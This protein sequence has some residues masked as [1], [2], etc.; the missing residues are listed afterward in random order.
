[1]AKSLMKALH[2]EMTAD[3][4]SIA[5]LLQKKGRGK[6]TV[7][8]HITPK[9]AAL[10]KKRG[11]RG[12]TNP[13]TG[14]LEFDDSFNAPDTG[15]SAE[16][17]PVGA[18][19]SQAP[20]MTASSFGGAPALP[21]GGPI[22]DNL[23]AQ[24]FTPQTT[25]DL[26]LQPPVSA[27]VIAPVFGEGSAMPGYSTGYPGITQPPTRF[28]ETQPDFGTAP[29]ATP[30]AGAAPEKSLLQSLGLNKANTL[31]AGLYGLLGAYQARNAA[32]QGQQAKQELLAQ[33]TPYQ[34]QGKQ[35]VTAAQSGQLSP[36]SAQAYQA[37]QAKAAQA[38]Q[39]SGGG[40]GVVQSQAALENLRQQL[41][42]GDL[43]IG[44]QIQAIGDKIAQGAISAGVQA[45]QYV[46][47]L[48]SNYAMNIGRVLMG[49]SPETTTKPGATE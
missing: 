9:E 2:T 7:L 33:A 45:D 26:Q 46:N 40:I 35:L 25:P 18:T 10:L 42:A 37:A 27:P 11:G 36:A 31:G 29:Q 1:M 3:L 8:A 34:Q 22:T 43:N 28:A 17:A 39:S 13:D 20:D 48:T 38:A 19:I 30:A 12:S 23:P 24:Q 15:F 5:A 49:T 16:F 21:Q 47:S 6:D 32:N 41:L 14:L 44:L 4:P